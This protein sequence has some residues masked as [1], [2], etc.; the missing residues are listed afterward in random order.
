MPNASSASS[1]NRELSPRWAPVFRATISP[2][3]MKLG[4][5]PAPR[6]AVTASAVEV[7]L[8]WVPANPM[9][10]DAAVSASSRVGR[11]HTVTPARRAACTSGSVAGTAEEKTTRSIASIRSGR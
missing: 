9:A 1:T 3:T 7:V 8:P 4:S 11:G 2:P 6:S 5:S 10:G